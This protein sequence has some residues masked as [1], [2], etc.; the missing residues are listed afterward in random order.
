MNKRAIIIILAKDKEAANK[1]CGELVEGGE[2]TFSIGA[3]PDG[4]EPITHYY[5]NWM[6]TAEQYDAMVAEFDMVYDVP[7]YDF[8]GVLA[9]QGIMPIQTESEGA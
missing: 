1:F 6:M 4:K 3:S 5:C 8:E 9:E 2:G 7:P